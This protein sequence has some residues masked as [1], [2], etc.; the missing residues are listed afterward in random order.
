MMFVRTLLTIQYK[1]FTPICDLGAV[2]GSTNNGKLDRESQSG[3]FTQVNLILHT[4]QL[5][6]V[7][8]NLATY[9]C[10]CV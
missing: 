9:L 6:D 7:D 4:G 8:T 10:M 3:V 5:A 1:N 2:K